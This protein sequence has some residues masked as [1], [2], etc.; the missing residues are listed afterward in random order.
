MYMNIIYDIGL[1]GDMPEIYVPTP[2]VA[3]GNSKS[4]DTTDKRLTIT[5]W[6]ITIG[7]QAVSET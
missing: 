2:C 3:S 5:N 1:Y 7:F 6:T 4:I